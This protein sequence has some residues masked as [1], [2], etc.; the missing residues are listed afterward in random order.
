M[1]NDMRCDIRS[2]PLWGPALKISL[3]LWLWKMMMRAVPCSSTTLPWLSTMSLVFKRGL[4]KHC[5]SI[6][7]STSRAQSFELRQIFWH[8]MVP[9]KWDWEDA[10][11]LYTLPLYSLGTKI[12][13]SIVWAL[14][15][16]NLITFFSGQSVSVFM[17]HYLYAWCY[18]N[19]SFL[20]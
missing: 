19:S 3:H 12:I 8:I 5:Q 20:P 17:C 13:R 4:E 18:S 7:D 2:A 15:K 9:V 16:C 11:N 6:S 1:S 14:H 10:W